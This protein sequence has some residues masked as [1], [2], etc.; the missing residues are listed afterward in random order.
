MAS[1][2]PPIADALAEPG[3]LADP[4][5][6]EAP[7]DPAGDALPAFPVHVLPPW[8]G[9]FVA[10][11]AE[12]VQVPAEAV[13]LHAL[14]ALAAACQGRHIVAVRA[15][16]WESLCLY[17]AVIFA[18]A[19]RKSALQR[20]TM[21]PLRD[22]EAAEAARLGPEV[23]AAASARRIAEAQ[24]QAEERE[25]A[26]SKDPLT[27]ARAEALA[28]ELADMPTATVPQLVAD[29]LTAEALGM[30]MAAQGGRL[31]IVSPEASI[32]DSVGRYRD[33]GADIGLLLKAHAGDPDKLGR[34]GR[35]PVHLHRPTL[36][37]AV[38]AQ[39]EYLTDLRQRPG[40]RGRGLLG[41][42]WWAVP[43]STVGR[44]KADPPPVPPAVADA[45]AAGLRAL[46]AMPI[47]RDSRGEIAPAV[48]P[49]DNEAQR[50]VVAY[51]DYVEPRLGPGGDLHEV[52]DWAG[53][54]VGTVARIAG[55]LAL[56]DSP[57][58]M[59]ACVNR[60]HVARAIEIG[61]WAIPHARAALAGGPTSREAIALQLVHE[62]GEDGV[63]VRELMR[64]RKR[65]FPRAAGARAAL[66]GLVDAGLCED[67]IRPTASG[68]DPVAFVA[69][70]RDNR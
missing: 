19:H 56:A 58:T 17:I 25:A 11:E 52:G 35:A 40:Y 13:A 59:P 18:V 20:D 3:T 55:L 23:A 27:R 15:G 5:A 2:Y 8:I 41:R 1:T 21:K 26:K 32:L 30:T 12:A 38:C 4:V 22:W 7:P 66:W 69:V 49:L 67:R 57:G 28:R 9:A 51:T 53:K 16:W 46:L 50:V 61:T 47:D 63:T 43:E 6:P 31:A 48:L 29:D 60:G 45:Y 33:S 64:R 42:F 34:V 14:A 10:A 24:L 36:T 44:R 37:I 70:R 68:P 39:P 62:A 65:W 54:L